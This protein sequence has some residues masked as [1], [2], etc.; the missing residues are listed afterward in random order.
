M[1]LY[2][3]AAQA[4]GAAQRGSAVATALARFGFGEFLTSTGLDKI[5]RGVTG[6]DLAPQAADAPIATRVR[7]LLES[8]GPTYI[9]AGQILSTRPDLIPPEW[10]AEFKKLQSEIPPAPWDGP[11]GVRAALEAEYGQ[12][13]EQRFAAVEPV[14]FAAASIGQV[15]R[16]TLHSGERIVL[17]VLRPGIREV[18]RS[19]LDLLQWLAR[20]S[21]GHFQGFGVDAEAVVAEFARQLDRET[22]LEIEARSTQRLADLF[23]GAPG[24][25][26]PRVH[27]AHTRR[28]VLAL[29]EVIGTPLSR[30]DPA[31]FPAGTRH[32]LVARAADAVFRQCLEFGFFH[33]DPHPGNILAVGPDDSPG[34]V[35]IDCGM[36]GLIDPGTMD[37]LAH[38]VHGT[39]ESDLPRVA[40]TALALAGADPALADDRAFRADVYRVIDHFKGG[41]IA[42][43][44]MGR[45]LD[46]FFGVLRDHQLRCPPDIVY[47]IKAMTTIEG[48]AREIA[49]DFDLIA[50][51]RPYAERLVRQRY[52]A[53]SIRARL[54]RSLV[55]YTDLAED[56]PAE[57]TGLLRQAK[58]NKLALNLEHKGLGGLTR[59]IERAS[60]NIS[61]SLVLAALI[62]GAALLVLADSLDRSSGVLAW[63]AGALF[64]GAIVLA[65]ARLLWGRFLAR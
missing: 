14:A 44:S 23:A 1:D 20:L 43:I 15:H 40:R 32:A 41:S 10:A 65:A 31:S 46:E 58:H 28:G 63:I 59:E 45:L 9:K 19:D 18:L 37:Q 11:D 64:V 60:M 47:L 5:V 62:V 50:H 3:R 26:F 25:G 39:V 22:D 51:V 33:A 38:L 29:D 55:A 2:A 7:L 36:T 24:I 34:V 4:I 8:L 61:W 57:V 54:L 48:V 21:R 16:A 35:F 6:V 13:L 56:L 12:P 49:P 27:P 42:S 30:L 17:K 52:S 53:G